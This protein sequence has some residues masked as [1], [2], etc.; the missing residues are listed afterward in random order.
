MLDFRFS[1]SPEDA[2]GKKRNNLNIWVFSTQGW[3]LTDIN[4]VICVGFILI[5]LSVNLVI[6]IFD[7]VH[8]M[9]LFFVMYWGLP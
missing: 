9:L 3:F 1:S 8:H 4:I 2:T 7:S 6:E 5:A